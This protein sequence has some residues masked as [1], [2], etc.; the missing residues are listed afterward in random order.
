M[1]TYKKYDKFS[2]FYDMFEASAEKNKLE[3]GEVCC[4]K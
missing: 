3:T 4:L 1:E 2:R